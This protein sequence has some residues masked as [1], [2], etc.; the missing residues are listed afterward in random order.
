M[1]RPRSDRPDALASKLAAA[2]D[3]LGRARRAA[4]Q[5]AATELG[6]TPLQVELIAVLANG[7]PP[8][9]GVGSLAAELAVSQPTTTDSLR[10]LAAKGLLERRPDP[11]DRR[12]SIHTLTPDGRRVARRLDQAD[13]VLVEVIGAIAVADQ[14][15][16]LGVLLRLIAG[17]VDRGAIDVARTCLTCSF[18]R[19]SGGI[20]HCTLLDV[21]LSPSELRVNCPEHVAA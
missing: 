10:A 5:S 16:T 4:R 2:I 6:L 12:R 17:L 14:A 3:Q 18:H 21:D 13:D 9:P 11:G 19:S 20:D 1:S 8:T 15:A 7:T